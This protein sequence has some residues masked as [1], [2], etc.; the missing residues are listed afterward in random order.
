MSA[1]L[2]HL[3]Y[4]SS[5]QSN[6]SL[7]WGKVVLGVAMCTDGSCVDDNDLSIHGADSTTG[8]SDV[9]GPGQAGSTAGYMNILFLVYQAPE[10]V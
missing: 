5:R 8:T 6:S 2:E 7:G 10:L 9:V 4:Q 1:R 3:L